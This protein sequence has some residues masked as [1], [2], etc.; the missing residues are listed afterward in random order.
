MGIQ[1]SCDNCSSTLNVKNEYAGRQARC[2]KCSTVLKVPS[3]DAAGEVTE[4]FDSA[5]PLSDDSSPYQSNPYASPVVSKPI[6][7][8]KN[9]GGTGQPTAV[10]PGRVI[11]YAFE[12][13]KDNLGLFVGATLFVFMVAFAISFVAEF[14]GAMIAQMAGDEFAGKLFSVLTD[15]FLGTLINW[16]LA[17]GLTRIMLSAARGEVPRFDMLFSGGNVF[18]AYAIG[19]ILFGLGVLVGCILLI[20]PGIIF[21]LY[22]WPYSMFIVDG[23]AATFGSFGEASAIAKMN[24]GT[25]LVLFF[26]SIG[27]AL[28]GLLAFCVGLIFAAPLVSCI[29]ATAYLMMKGEIR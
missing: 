22:Y 26:A 27:I 4:N 9:T 12:V 29:F 19:G 1:F 3:P 25:S 18:I 2:P 7:S 6:R 15:N 20:V 5:Q 17:I 28:A 16:F 13:W 14:G 11:E 23:E 21:A 10:G 24:I 8:S